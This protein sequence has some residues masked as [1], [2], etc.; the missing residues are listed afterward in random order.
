[1][2]DLPKKKRE[3]LIGQ[4][5]QGLAEIWTLPDFCAFHLR[6]MEKMERKDYEEFLYLHDFYAYHLQIMEK[7]E[8]T[9][10]EELNL[11]KGCPV[12]HA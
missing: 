2:S 10:Y 6:I 8:K 5:W 12:D 9:D 3:Y 11:H 1:M 4:S 7:R